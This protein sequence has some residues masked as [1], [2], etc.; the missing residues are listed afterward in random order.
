M[1]VFSHPFLFPAQFSRAIHGM[2]L[3]GV[4]FT[5]FDMPVPPAMMAGGRWV[6]VVPG[7]AQHAA[8]IQQDLLRRRAGLVRR[9]RAA[10]ITHA[11][12]D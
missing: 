3:I 5:G 7:P 12:C 6:S 1:L 8:P 9:V 11:R 10:E 4:S 2:R